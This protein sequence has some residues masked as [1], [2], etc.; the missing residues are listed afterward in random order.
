[1]DPVT[2]RC[3]FSE[4]DLA[5]FLNVPR[6]IV[7]AWSKAFR[8]IEVYEGHPLA[9]FTPE[10]LTGMK[11]GSWCMMTFNTPQ[12]NGWLIAQSVL[13]RLFETMNVSCRC[14]FRG[15]PRGAGPQAG[16][17]LLVCAFDD[18]GG[19][20]LPLLGLTK[21]EVDCSVWIDITRLNTAIRDAINGSIRVGPNISEHPFMIARGINVDLPA[22]LVRIGAKVTSLPES[23]R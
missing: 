21:H 13:D 9:G 23:M 2:P 22:P 1:M 20:P 3:Q 10:Q 15:I 6:E 12:R 11:L 5:I 16:A 19:V 7:R 18:E 14:I 17:R 8:L 4:R